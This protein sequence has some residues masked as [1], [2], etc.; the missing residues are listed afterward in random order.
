[1]KQSYKDHPSFKF[2]CKEY[3]LKKFMIDEFDEIYKTIFSSERFISKKHQK[4]T[5]MELSALITKIFHEMS[6]Q[7]SDRY[8]AAFLSELNAAVVELLNHELDGFDSTFKN[9]P[10]NANNKIMD[11]LRLNRSYCGELQAWAIKKIS[12][13]CLPEVEVLRN[14]ARL[15]KVARSDLSINSGKTIRQI[16]KVLNEAFKERG[17]LDCVSEYMGASYKV[18]GAALELS[19]PSSTWWRNTLDRAVPPQTMYAHID[20][21]IHHPKAIVYLSNVCLD[22]GPTTYYPGVYERLELNAL[23]ELIGR[24]ICKVGESESSILYNYYDRN[25]S[26]LM[27]SSNFRKHFMRLPTEL[28][29]NS[30]FGW[31]VL[32]GSKF[33]ESM[34]ASEKKMIGNAGMYIVFDGGRLLHRGGLISEGERIVLQVIFSRIITFPN[35]L[36]AASSKFYKK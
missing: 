18:G 25:N 27:G 8:E 21:S 11:E 28:R 1:M 24:V 7:A 15:G 5:F 36:I 26:K 4:N 29:F 32:A 19:V 23:Q 30:H 3:N 14:N 13:A 34:L 2:H 12:D 22:N 33:E 17:I 31:D 16:V 10:L 20:E 35:R 9:K 6:V